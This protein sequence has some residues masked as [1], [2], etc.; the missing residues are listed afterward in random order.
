MTL[1]LSTP[2]YLQIGI[3]ICAVILIGCIGG[4]IYLKY[5]KGA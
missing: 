3:I 4:W 5:R 2:T 1:E